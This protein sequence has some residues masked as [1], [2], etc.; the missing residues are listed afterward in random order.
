MAVDETSIFNGKLVIIAGITKSNFLHVEFVRNGK[1]EQ[2][3]LLT[4]LEKK[5][6]N[7]INIGLHGVLKLPDVW[8]AL[9]WL[10]GV[11]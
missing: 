2:Q 8:E 7:P 3:D 1:P 6:P 9:S 11:W 5:S 4:A 10:D